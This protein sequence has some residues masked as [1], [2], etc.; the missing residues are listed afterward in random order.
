MS[1]I[2]GIVNLDGAP[3]DRALMERLTG[4]MS[5]RGPDAREVWCEGQAGFG[6]A[7]L[8]TTAEAETERQPLSFDGQVWL[9]A[10]AR[11][12]ARADLIDQL[13]AKGRA[14]NNA[15][16]AELILHAYLAWGE[17][18]VEHLLGDF[19][20]VIWDGPR[21][22]LFCAR[23]HLG[24]KL[25]YFAR[26]GNSLIVSNTLNCIRQHPGVSAELNE[27]AI[28]D[29]LL[30]G[31]NFD[32]TR[33]TFADINR[34]SPAHVLVCADGELR[35]TCYW[36]LTA[37]DEIRYQRASDYVDRFKELLARAVSDRLRTRQAAVTLTGGLDSTT[38]AATAL[39]LNGVSLKA[40]T[41]VYDSLIPDRER[42]YAQLVADTL[43]LPISYL[44]AD[45]YWLYRDWEKPKLRR[46]E[47]SDEPLLATFADYLECMAKDH[48][49]ALTGWDG[50][51]L[52]RELPRYYFKTIRK[53]GRHGRFCLDTMRYVLAQGE[54]P[55][56]GFRTA[57]KGFF[58]TPVPEDGA[59]FPRW[60][61]PDFAA[62]FNLKE[63][64]EEVNRDLT[65]SHRR[66]PT[67]ILSLTAPVWA[68]LFE[69]YDPGVTGF[70][71]ELRHPLFDLRLIKYLLSLPP[72]P[73]C[74]EKRLLRLAARGILPEEVRTRP[75]ARLAGHPEV[76]QLQ[77]PG[78]EWI[79][80]FEPT[81]RL[82]AYVDR[83]LIPPLARQSDAN[84]VE[85]N[86]RPLSL[87]FWL[88]DVA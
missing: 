51:S 50:D 55:P 68:G 83:K 41:I 5:F 69:Y 44:A 77:R 10:D 82:A 67:A 63:R 35:Q 58:A 45:D 70:P 14:A 53:A 26:A 8:R 87:N 9:T 34:L 40:Y 16:D 4:F 20:F 38:I 12:D 75:K 59:K 57:L 30:C 19:A 46:P 6:H 52:L 78:V 60:L 79:D 2:V 49:V 32:Q 18:C 25:L 36:K 33:T 73:W 66:R 22:K 3:V 71:L 24:V 29:F 31:T 39:K 47:P 15:N 76:E 28:G 7:M 23:D 54:L 72:V 13:Q 56:I 80:Q 43:G 1:G 65:P 81:S 62:R 61:N 37:D 85:T 48:R 86:T 21:R 17:A 84:V 27:Q 11:I 42:H 88:R 74:I 64:W